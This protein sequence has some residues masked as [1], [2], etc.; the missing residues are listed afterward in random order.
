MSQQAN[1]VAFD[2]AGTPA[3][4]TLT[5]IGVAKDAV[6]GLVA[7]WREILAGVPNGAQ[8][9]LRMTK[10]T[11]KSGVERISIDLRI[12]V[13]ESVS[14]QNAAGYTAAPKVAF[15]DQH[16]YV[17]Y[18]SERSAQ[19]NRRLGRQWLV[20]IINGVATTVTPV[21]TGNAAELVDSAIFPS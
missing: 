9:T 10:R 3:T 7:D 5:T 18:F 19:V 20:N 1:I 16:S 14:G 12:S 8:P 6:A 17:G 21:T 11:L 4:H 15:T 13:M 2:G